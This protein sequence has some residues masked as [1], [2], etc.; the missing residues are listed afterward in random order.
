MEIW[1]DNE[2]L[3]EVGKAGAEQ[4]GDGPTKLGALR[5]L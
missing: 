1:E 3:S 4:L 5:G 2:T